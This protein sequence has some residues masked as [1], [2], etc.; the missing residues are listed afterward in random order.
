YGLVQWEYNAA[1]DPSVFE[2]SE[3]PVGATVWDGTPVTFSS[4]V[5][6]GGD[7]IPTFQW[8]QSINDGA[9]WD[10]IPGAETASYALTPATVA[11][12]RNQYRVVVTRGAET[13]TSEPAL[14][15]VGDGEPVQP[16]GVV[17]HFRF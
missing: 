4:V 15:R 17:A 13:L 7:L 2:F 10:P 11:M 8:E 3:E 14:L 9:S 5:A 12:D 1:L 16:G 6:S